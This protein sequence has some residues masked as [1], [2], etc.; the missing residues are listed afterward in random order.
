MYPMLFPIWEFE[1]IEFHYILNNFVDFTFREA[2]NI[3][4]FTNLQIRT[5]AYGK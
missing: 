5:P 4:N 2:H 1:I 3:L